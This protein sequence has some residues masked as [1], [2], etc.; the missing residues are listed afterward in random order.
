MEIVSVVILS[1][2]FNSLL[3][4]LWMIFKEK[5]SFSLG[6][7][8]GS[9]SWLSLSSA[10]GEPQLMRHKRII[11]WLFRENEIIGC[12]EPK[13]Y[14]F[15][16]LAPLEK[17]ILLEEKAYTWMLATMT[18]TKFFILQIRIPFHLLSLFSAKWKGNEVSINSNFED[19]KNLEG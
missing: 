8:K 2:H 18:C 10:F 11:I 5:T 12:Y 16:N 9:V 19:Y 4:P 3:C 7:I 14:D 6:R 13:R 17:K 1:E 15:L